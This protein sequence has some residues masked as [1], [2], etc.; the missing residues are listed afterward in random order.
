MKGALERPSFPI[1]GPG[2]SDDETHH[3]TIVRRH[4]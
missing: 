3:G 1:V 2:V 4:D